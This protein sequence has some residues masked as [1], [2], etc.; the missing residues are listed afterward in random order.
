VENEALV[1]SPG[2]PSALA[3]HR[4]AD[5]PFAVSEYNH[6]LP[7]VY[8]AEGFP[9]IA[10]IGGF[11]GWD[12][13]FSFAYSHD[14]D[15]EPRRLISF[16]D[17]KQDPVRLVHMPACVAMFVRGDVAPARTLL[18]VPL[19]AD[20]EK[21]Q[22][23]PTH[24]PWT[25][26]T[27]HLGLDPREAILHAVALDIG[28]KAGSTRGATGGLSASAGEAR[29]SPWHPSEAPASPGHTVRPWQPPQLPAGIKEFVSDTGQ[30][31]WNVEKP[32]G[33]YFVVNSPRCKLFT[34]FVRGRSFHLGDVTLEIGPSRL[35]WATVSLVAIDGAGCDKPGRLLLAA[36][37]W[38]Q[39]RGAVLESLGGDRVTL[40]D[41]WGDEPVLCEGI[42]ARIVLPVASDRVRFYP[43]DESGNRRAAVL[44][45]SRD[46]H[47]LLAIGPQYRTLWYEV[48]IRQGPASQ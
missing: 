12:A 27:D 5:K 29:A 7:N 10:A 31:R 11:Q 40:R 22:L 21:R 46:G 45:A 36:S 3:G 47:A 17:I 9:I 44:P 38:E 30:I 33:G 13:I 2:S 18:R 24:S 6:P 23:H 14:R 25:L 8:A 28:P 4:V 1:N 32:D 20:A 42:A 19:G 15:Y 35:D 16:F 37:G 43:L 26:T 41:R 48:E 34:G 39:N